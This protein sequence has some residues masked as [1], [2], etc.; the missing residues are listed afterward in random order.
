MRLVSDT[1]PGVA[2]GVRHDSASISHN[3][4]I[5]TEKAGIRPPAIAISNK[6]GGLRL[7]RHE[8]GR[9]MS[10]TP[11]TI[12]RFAHTAA[13]GRATAGFSHGFKVSSNAR[14]SADANFARLVRRANG[15]T[16]PADVRYEWLCRPFPHVEHLREAGVGLKN[17]ASATN[18][19]RPSDN[20]VGFGGSSGRG[21]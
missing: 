4:A 5:A 6:K 16:C 13:P 17:E 19:Q 12:P 2:P 11:A 9:K 14:A 15:V 1:A 3:P 10:A 20:L 7:L 8:K 18:R 21:V